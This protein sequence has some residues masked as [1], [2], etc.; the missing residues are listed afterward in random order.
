MEDETQSF[1]FSDFSPPRN[2]F[3][4][5]IHV[6][7]SI[8]TIKYH[9]SSDVQPHGSPPTEN[10]SGEVL[11]WEIASPGAGKVIQ[12][13]MHQKPHKKWSWFS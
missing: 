6:L 13:E 9:L 1:L 2:R 10:C 8:S 11:R 5:K 3:L 7:P 4:H 12:V